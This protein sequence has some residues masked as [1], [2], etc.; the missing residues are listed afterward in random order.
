MSKATREPTNRELL[1]VVVQAR[2][3]VSV[4][5][6]A[7]AQ[8]KVA[9]VLEKAPTPVLFARVDLVA[10]SDPA[11]ERPSFAKAEADI[12]G[13][14]VRAHVAGAT[15]REAIDRLEARLTD[16]LERLVHHQEAKHLRFRG[17]KEREWRHGDIVSWRPSYFPRPVEERELVR[18]KT[19]ALHA[20]TPD[21]AALELELL[22]HD[23]YLFVNAETGEDNV[24]ARA[25][26]DAYELLEPSA[27]S[28]LTETIADVRHSPI[29]PST[30]PIEEA[31]KLLD[32]G[33]EPFVFFLDPT[34]RR[35]HVVYRRYDGHYGLIVPA[36]QD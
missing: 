23:F 33:N 5:E 13:R 1:E 29:R 3:A 18:R 28:S 8:T 22:D 26:G 21:E 19:F 35:G 25:D 4:D 12:N 31:L 14:L 10:H 6:R 24:I 16:R 32:L 7:Y 9:H 17:D 20:V 36:E 34:S 15:M 11:R 2:G 30:M 27:T